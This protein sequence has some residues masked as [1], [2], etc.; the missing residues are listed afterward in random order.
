MCPPL[1]LDIVAESKRAPILKGETAAEIA[2]RLVIQNR[3]KNRALKRAIV[4][5]EECRKG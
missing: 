4:A 3:T 2:A 5:H 1:A